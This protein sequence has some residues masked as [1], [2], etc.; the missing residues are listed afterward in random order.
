LASA[1]LIKK[2]ADQQPDL[3]ENLFGALKRC[4]K[5]R[6]RLTRGG[7]SP[8]R[9]APFSF[10]ELPATIGP[11][12]FSKTQELFTRR[13]SSVVWRYGPATPDDWSRQGEIR[14]PLDC[15]VR[16]RRF[17]ANRAD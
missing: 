16:E 7:P 8:S 2:T 12:H 1:R 10:L 14:K 4:D 17:T 3:F 15:P 11:C 9:A 13:L 6:A 5:V